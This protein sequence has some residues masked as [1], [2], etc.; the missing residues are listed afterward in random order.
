M[1]KFITTREND[2][3]QKINHELIQKIT[4]QIV[5]YY[6]IVIPE[7][8][9]HDLYNEAVRKTWAPPVAC[10]ARVL[11]DNAGVTSTRFA[12]D[13]EFS[14]EVYFHTLELQERNV[15]PREGDF[16]EFGSVY[17]EITAV[18]QPQIVFGQI[19]EKIMTKC[20]CVKSREGQFAAGA[21]TDVN[22]DR[23]HPVETPICTSC[24]DGGPCGVH[25]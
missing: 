1:P 24:A 16:I 10:N 21:Q 2:F 3:I 18:T 12:P 13:A 14:L 7:T 4:G 22:V 19:N 5:H 23:G 20:I 17:F 8:K 25:D 15:L 9:V 6:A 11:W